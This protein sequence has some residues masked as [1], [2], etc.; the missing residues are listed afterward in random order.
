MKWRND[1]MEQDSVR[2][3]PHETIYHA[4]SC[5]AIIERRKFVFV[6]EAKNIYQNLFIKQN[7]GVEFHFIFSQQRQCC[8]MFSYIF[9]REIKHGF[10]MAVLSAH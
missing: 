10:G 6:G 7:F 9:T 2:H 3:E 5:H 1:W 4:V 8:A